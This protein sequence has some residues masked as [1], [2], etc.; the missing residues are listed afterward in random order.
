MSLDTEL[1]SI[2]DTRTIRGM[3][4]SASNKREALRVGDGEPGSA[5]QNVAL[6]PSSNWILKSALASWTD[7]TLLP[8]DTAAAPVVLIFM[9]D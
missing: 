3:S 4:S 9:L 7:F 5:R 8:G 6:D 2:D 1:C